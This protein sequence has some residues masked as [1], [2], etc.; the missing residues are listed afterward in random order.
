MVLKVA[1]PVILTL[2]EPLNMFA[3]FVGQ[4]KLILVWAPTDGVGGVRGVLLIFVW[5]MRGRATG[6]VGAAGMEDWRRSQVSISGGKSSFGTTRGGSN[7]GIGEGI[8]CRSQ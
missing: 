6:E 3:E 2:E 4:L 7:E 5:R 8:L 1:S